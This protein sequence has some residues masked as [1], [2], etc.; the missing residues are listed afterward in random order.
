MIQLL[1]LLVLWTVF[2]VSTSAHPRFRHELRF[3]ERSSNDRAATVPLLPSLDP[4]YTAPTGWE[5]TQPGAILRLRQAP[6]LQYTIGN[7][8][9]VYQILYRTT[10]S[11]FNPSWAVTTLFIP[12]WQYRCTAATQL[13]CAHALL[14]YQLPYDSANIDASPSYALHGGEPYGEIADSLYRGWFVSVPDYEGPKASFTAGLTAGHAT[15]DSVR[16]VLN[17]AGNFGLRMSAKIALWGYSGGALASE[18]A[19]GEF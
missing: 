18:W 16:A 17:V 5:K 6:Y 3:T 10:D 2:T 13:L 19:A 7:A 11:L 12:D 4:W 8:L 15:I 14:S 1:N 9:I